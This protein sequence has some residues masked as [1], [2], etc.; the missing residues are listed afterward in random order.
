[1]LGWFDIDHELDAM[2]DFRRRV[3]RIFDDMTRQP[4]TPGRSSGRWPRANLWDEGEALA[5]ELGV[6]GVALDDLEINGHGD[7]LTISGVRRVTAPDGYASHR[8]ER[9]GLRFARSINLPVK[10]E[11]DR[12]EATLD[13]GIL[14]VRLPKAPE[15]KPRSIQVRAG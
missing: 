3:D 14:T 12:A 2:E 9:A 11:L 10:V 4:T 7:T 1:M 15:L 8:Q 13:H 5:L 6:P